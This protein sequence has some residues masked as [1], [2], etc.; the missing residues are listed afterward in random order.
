MV[1]E[2]VLVD[3]NNITARQALNNMVFIVD[4]ICSKVTKLIKR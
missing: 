3:T 1:E 4:M 2:K